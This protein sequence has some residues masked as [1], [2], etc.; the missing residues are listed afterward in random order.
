[1]R[2]ERKKRGADIMPEDIT[3]PITKI[4]LKEN[5][6][7]VAVFPRDIAKKPTYEL[8]FFRVMRRYPIVYS[9]DTLPE[10][11]AGGKTNFGFL[12]DVGLNAGNDKITIWE[13]RPYRLYHFGIGVRPDGIRV[14]RAIPSGVP[15]TGLGYMEPTEVGSPYDYFDSDTS[16]YDAPTVV[17][18]T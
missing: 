3:T 16:P 15:Q 12:G 14:Y 11:P 7:L 1:M 13:E 5:E 9:Y 10:I 6:N 17:S 8:Y 4:L 18:E 2:L